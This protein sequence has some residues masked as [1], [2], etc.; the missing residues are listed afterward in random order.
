MSS[1]STTDNPLELSWRIPT[2]GDPLQLRLALAQVG[3]ATVV[4]GLAI[5]VAAPREWLAPALLGLIP[6]ALF[7]AYRRWA[8]YQ[9]S[10]AGPDNV[11]LDSTGLHWL[12]M[13]GN[14]QS[15]AKENV[16][17]FRIAQADDTLRPVPALT[18]SLAGGFE[19][20]PVELHPPATEAAV[21][22]LLT[23]EWDL[24]ER[25]VGNALRGVPDSG[26][27]LALDIY[28]ECHD[29]FQ[30]WHFE[31][32]RAAL[33]ELELAIAEAAHLPLPPPGA[34]PLSRVLLLRRRDQSP[35]TLQHDRLGHVGSDAITLPAEKLFELS[36]FIATRLNESSA[37]PPP[38]DLKFDLPLGKGNVWTFHLHIR[39]P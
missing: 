29:E 6:L 32:T 9:Q 3:L 7:V 10:L 8:K 27:D 33:G 37:A 20:Q 25:A 12:D 38:L 22:R 18:L 39:E 13:A 14:G 15:F 5:L 21:R 4:G 23:T 36:R 17:A 1:E 35:L 30:E 31:G 11:R 28:S 19:S 34:K 16:V 24:P 26:Y 2:T